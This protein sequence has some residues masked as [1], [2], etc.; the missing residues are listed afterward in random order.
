MRFTDSLKDVE[1]FKSLLMLC[2]SRNV[3]L[4]YKQG[5]RSHV[6][7]ARQQKQRT[8]ASASTSTSSCFT[9]FTLL[10][11]TLLVYF[12]PSS[13][14][15]TVSLTLAYHSFL[16]PFV[17]LLPRTKQVSQSTLCQNGKYND[18]NTFEQLYLSY[19]TTSLTN[20]VKRRQ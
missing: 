19:F 1:H 9:C 6:I 17:S 20:Y 13:V 11:F 10:F 4:C 12:S 16:Q 15:F 8:S 3:S 14:H 2:F 5:E 7:A 18:S